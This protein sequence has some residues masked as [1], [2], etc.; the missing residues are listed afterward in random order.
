MRTRLGSV[1]RT[2]RM[3]ANGCEEVARSVACMYR[4]ATRQHPQLDTQF[5]TSQLRNCATSRVPGTGS[6]SPAYQHLEQ[7]LVLVCP[8]CKHSAFF[9][10]TRGEEQATYLHILNVRILDDV[11]VSTACN[12]VLDSN[13][14]ADA[15]SV[16][17]GTNRR[18][19][20]VP[21]GIAQQLLWNGS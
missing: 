3:K 19:E 12:S 5:Y 15:P 8:P 13:A 2:V 20:T 11:L 4:A 16:F 18:N 14:R 9:Y 10:Y 1:V 7:D 21:T 6:G 17:V